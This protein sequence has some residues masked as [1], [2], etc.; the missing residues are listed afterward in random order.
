MLRA[1]RPIMPDDV[2]KTTV[3][4]QYADGTINGTFQGTDPTGQYVVSGRVA[5]AGLSTGG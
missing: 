5:G 4:A 1:L 3:R 2:N